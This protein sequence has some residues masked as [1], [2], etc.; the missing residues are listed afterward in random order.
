MNR[1][2]LKCMFLLYGSRVEV[3]FNVNVTFSCN[4]LQTKIFYFGTFYYLKSNYS[5]IIMCCKLLSVIH[6]F[7]TY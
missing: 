1:L 6:L 2:K 4:N 7:Y 5:I 3:C